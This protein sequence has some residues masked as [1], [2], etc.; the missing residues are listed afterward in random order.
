M[1]GIRETIAEY[2]K[3]KA[4]PTKRDLLCFVGML[5]TGEATL[6]DFYAVG[7]ESLTLSVMK[8]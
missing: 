1:D 3:R 5:Q 7:G 6:A 4:E 2:M 8:E